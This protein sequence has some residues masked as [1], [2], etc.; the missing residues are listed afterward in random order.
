M[1]DIHLVRSRG[2][3]DS[4]GIRWELP[5]L[6][7]RLR[8]RGRGFATTPARVFISFCL[9]GSDFNLGLAVFTKERDRLD[10]RAHVERVTWEACCSEAERIEM[11]EA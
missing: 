6:P 5:L 8:R 3:C 1:I 11:V 2:A 10:V 4:T 9:F 7:W